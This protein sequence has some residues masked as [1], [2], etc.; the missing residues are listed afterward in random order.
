MKNDAAVP[1]SPAA[2]A[3]IDHVEVIPLRMPMK[4]PIKFSGGSRP[5]IDTL[6][7]RLHTRDGT[8]GVGE[9]QAW[10][11]QGSSET[12]ASLCAVIRDHFAPHLVGQSPFDIAAIM[13]RL[14][15]SVFHSL[16]AQAA[17]SDALFD[18]QGKLLGVPV[19]TLLGGRCRDR[20]AACVVLFMFPSIEET[21]A[22][23]KDYQARGFD[24]FTIKVG[25]DPKRD[26]QTIA[27][28]REALGEDAVIRVDA[29]A[30]MDF[31]SALWLLDRAAPYHLD[32]AEQLLPIWDVAGLAELA[33][34]STTPLMVDESLGTDHD[35]L[36]IVRQRAAT[37]IH[38][39]IG[40]NGGLWGCRKLWPIAA[41]A[42]MRIYPGNHPS[43]SIATL[44]VV[45]QAAAWPGPLLEGAF[46]VGIE[47]LA[48]D[49]VT[50][51]VRMNGNCVM[52]PDTPGLG[53][54]LDE[55]RVR[56]FRVQV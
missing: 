7:V 53:V 11:R 28:L 32:A 27:A 12:H 38:T 5:F 43:T 8:S 35:L 44:A 33:R 20:L 25:L 31:D 3:R 2:A 34:R 37:V 17:V 6:L 14:E 10:L 21:V 48:E 18:L 45:Q 13:Q 16:Y 26:L 1:P 54:E 24:S 19:H 52:V 56:A 41:A 39:K 22:S 15:D 23:A 51:P 36:A 42:G 46:A 4:S 29:N 30:G 9:T 49:V 40:K 50:Q 55:D 47:A